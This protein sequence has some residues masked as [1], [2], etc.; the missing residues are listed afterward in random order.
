[1]PKTPEAIR[2]ARLLW[3]LTHVIQRHMYPTLPTSSAPCLAPT[4][5]AIA[6]MLDW[7]DTLL[8]QWRQS[9]THA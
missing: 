4:D 5:A 9:R 2:E 3:P 6:Q 1:M 8:E 7:A